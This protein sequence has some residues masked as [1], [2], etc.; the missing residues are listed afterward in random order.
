MPGDPDPLYVKARKVLLDAFDA[1]ED[2]REALVL[3]G[4]QA[5]YVHTGDTDLAVAEFTTDADLSISPSDLANNPHIE[6]LL[7]N[8]G[9]RPGINPGSW[10]SADGVL[11]DL[12]VPE[13]LAGTGSRS[14]DLRPHGKPSARRAVGLEGSLIDR[15]KRELA[16]LDPSDKRA[17]T[18]WV[19]GPAALIIAKAYK[20][21]E[22]ITLPNRLI[23]KDALDLYRL[24]RATETRD[25]ADR[26]MV[27]RDSSL[28]GDVAS[29]A[30]AFLPELFGSV[31]ARGTRMAVRAAGDL[32]RTD[33]I[34]SSL[35]ALVSDLLAEV[36]EDS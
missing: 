30:I 35:V 27:L 32:E 6:D 2:H 31:D 12:M 24:L 13:T 9:F 8:A 15:D 23:D 19:A 25:V 21:H 26:L 29:R 10:L 1:L 4:A 18:I 3:V 33:I 36:H 28:A 5:V 16:S 17:Q 22:R 20:I 34:A 14:A 7:S 11:V